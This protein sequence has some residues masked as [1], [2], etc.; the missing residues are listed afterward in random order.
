VQAA[1][2]EGAAAMV[3]FRLDRD[4]VDGAQGQ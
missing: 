4:A 1:V 2:D 3:E